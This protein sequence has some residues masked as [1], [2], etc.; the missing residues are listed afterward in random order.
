MRIRTP[1]EISKMRSRCPR[2]AGSVPGGENPR[3]ARRRR[4]EHVAKTRPRRRNPNTAHLVR[5]RPD[6]FQSGKR[7]G[8]RSLALHPRRISVSE[9]ML[10]NE[11]RWPQLRIHQACDPFFFTTTRLFWYIHTKQK[12]RRDVPILKSSGLQEFPRPR[13][14][15]PE[16]GVSDHDLSGCSLHVAPPASRWTRRNSEQGDRP[17]CR[18][19]SA[20]K[21]VY[22]VI[23]R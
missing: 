3:S 10:D 7:D 22:G 23:E 16:G 15:T 21:P 18:R 13:S 20:L 19:R 2:D 11:S 14:N 12:G 1:S 6:V 5:L 9:G 8:G 17:Y 4:H